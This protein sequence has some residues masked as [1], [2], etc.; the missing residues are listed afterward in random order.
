MSDDRRTQLFAVADKIVFGDGSGSATDRLSGI[1]EALYRLAASREQ[2]D[3]F[4]ARLRS[5]SS[6]SSVAWLALVRLA[7]L[8]LGEDGSALVRR[9]DQ[10]MSAATGRAALTLSTEAARHFHRITGS[11]RAALE[12]LAG[13]P[14]PDPEFAEAAVDAVVVRLRLAAAAGAWET[15]DRLAAAMTREW[16]RKAGPTAVL[17][18]I[19]RAEH[20]VQRGAYDAA[21]EAVRD[22]PS[23]NDAGLRLAGL[24]VRLH[25]LV[26]CSGGKPGEELRTEIA[27]TVEELKPL[28]QSDPPPG[29]VLS[30]DEWRDRCSR[31][32][33]L[34]EYTP[35]PSHRSDRTRALAETE[36]ALEKPGPKH[37]EVHLRLQLRWVRLS[38]AE[39]GSPFARTCEDI[40]DGVLDEAR[41]LGLV[42]V[43]M[44][45]WDLRAV[46]R[47][48]YGGSRWDEVVHDAGRAADLAAYLVAL[49]RGSGLERSLRATLLPV[50]DRTLELLV[51]GA[52]AV[53]SRQPSD[54]TAAERFGRAMHDYVEQVMQLALSEARSQLGA[55]DRGEH[56]PSPKLSWSE[57]MRGESLQA[58]LSP[59]QA[60]LQYFLVGGY[61]LAFAFG[62]DFFV[63]HAEAPEGAVPD[64]RRPENLLALR[65]FLEPLLPS[66]KD[67]QPC[68]ET[69]GVVSLWPDRKELLE[70]LSG[71]LLPPPIV[72]AL[73]RRRIRHLAI[74]P[75]DVLYRTTFSRLTW[76]KTRLGRR[77]LL[78]LE[79][80]AELAAA[81]ALE[82]RR[83]TC[84]RPRLGFFLGPRLKHARRERDELEKAFRGAV[85]FAHWDTQRLGKEVFKREAPR[86][87]VLYLACHGERATDTPGDACTPGDAYL[88]LG[89]GGDSLLLSE[90]VRFDL[91]RCRLAVLQACWTGWMDHLREAPV[92]G[93]PQG[94]RD[95]GAAAVIAP[96]FPVADALCP[97]FTAVFA[98]ALRFLP[99]AEA[100]HLTLGVL[101]R[102]RKTLAVCFPE[103]P[104]DWENDDT[105]DDYEYRFTGRSEP[106]TSGW[107]RRQLARV[108]FYG[109]LWR[110]VLF[111]PAVNE[112]DPRVSKKE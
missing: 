88:E 12:R 84:R 6:E 43:E 90:A 95:A 106:L 51:E 48:R 67:A 20:A 107:L 23:G 52:L 42:V 80:T 97:V 28:L 56:L 3:E 26:A 29:G 32:K 10:G 37:P 68:E 63:W 58:A 16:I 46:I 102:H 78:T 49:N 55:H 100:L 109:W 86:C 24:Q 112:A 30:T 15:H 66:P 25:V 96:M 44:L 82:P 93:F 85:E 64:D 45:A 17:I 54:T 34:L 72:H 57:P 40:V 92:H 47:A 111:P 79:P 110:R 87:D 31:G 94:L 27:R 11:A 104:E 14:L 22:L 105:F 36:K 41:R 61:L 18:S 35:E 77:F 103:A 13:K 101:Q 1:F 71:H 53:R 50:F 39:H 60:V 99:V 62:Q 5:Y 89:P 108:G 65:T 69:R 38:L 19:T 59:R 75:H 76:R 91:G 70:R 83:R 21:L 98:R 4:E 8:R 73:D 33:Q 81:H 74:V 7:Q 2:L 9:L